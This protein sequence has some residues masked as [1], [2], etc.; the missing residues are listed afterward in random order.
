MV[1]SLYVI[2]RSHLWLRVKHKLCS[3]ICMC[4]CACVCLSLIKP[5]VHEVDYCSQRWVIL[6]KGA[7]KVLLLEGLKTQLKDIPPQSE[8]LS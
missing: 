7:H 6:Q 8:L 2:T 1:A 5:G 4:V 3:C